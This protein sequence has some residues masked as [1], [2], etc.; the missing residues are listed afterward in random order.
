MLA[1]AV[2]ERWSAVISAGCR[3]WAGPNGPA[4]DIAGWLGSSGG[5]GLGGAGGSPEAASEP[6]L[7]SA[8][9]SSPG[10]WLDSLGSSPSAMGIST[11]SPSGSSGAGS[12]ARRGR[13]CGRLAA[14]RPAEVGRASP[15]MPEL[16]RPGMPALARSES[17]LALPETA[18]TEPSVTRTTMATRRPAFRVLASVARTTARGWRRICSPTPFVS[19]TRLCGDAVPAGDPNRPMRACQ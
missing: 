15:G 10:E 14:C 9:V 7:C 3:A 19:F 18:V 11:I 12:F 5:D 13:R 6:S 16:V 17:A 1:Y 8:L 2:L 4:R